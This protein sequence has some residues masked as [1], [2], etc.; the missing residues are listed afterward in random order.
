MDLQRSVECGQIF[1]FKKLDEAYLLE[2][3]ENALL[4]SQG[5][6][7]L[8][9]RC[10]EN[11]LESWKG[12]LQVTK[13]Y[14]AFETSL[15]E[16]PAWSDVMNDSAGIRVFLQDPFEALIGFIVS[17]NNHFQRICN[18]V[19]SLCASYGDPKGE[20]ENETMYSFPQPEVLAQ[21]SETELRALGC[22]YR[23]PYIIGSAKAV[24]EGFSL[25]ELR[26]A[27]RETG[28]RELCKLPGVG[29][30]VAD[31]V[32]LYGLGNGECCPMDVWMKRVMAQLYPDL[33][34]KEALACFR[35]RYGPW[36]GAV[37]QY[38][39]HHARMEKQKNKEKKVNKRA[40]E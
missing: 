19:Q 37:Q 14:E 30:K 1:R 16:D 24:T 32:L 29:V 15:L 33:A 4:V 18:V 36:S 23:A 34:E 9:L 20:I 21:A 5:E 12:F 28:I 7:T 27:K 26:Y 11:E 8:C 3:K 39:F 17:A 31:C 10:D 2:S 40:K 38:F 13:E 22:G 6:D 35:E 25:E